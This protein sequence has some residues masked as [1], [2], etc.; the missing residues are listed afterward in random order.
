MWK[1]Y[2]LTASGGGFNPSSQALSHHKV[3]HLGF[4]HGEAFTHF[5]SFLSRDGYGVHIDEVVGEHWQLW[6]LLNWVPLEESKLNWTAMA[7]SLSKY[8]TFCFELVLQ[9]IPGLTNKTN[10]V[11]MDYW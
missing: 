11:M 4:S 10:I 8:S 1:T 7:G 5:P 2:K 9:Q 6:Y 3:S